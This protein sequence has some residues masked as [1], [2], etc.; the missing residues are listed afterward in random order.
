M[1]PI[2]LLAVLLPFLTA[3]LIVAIVLTVRYLRDKSKNEVIKRAI[4]AGK[5][6]T[7]EIFANFSKEGKKS[8]PLAA[9]LS[10][11]GAGIGIFLALYF[12]FGGLK[13]AAFGL[14]PLFVGIGQLISYFLNKK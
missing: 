4:E 8:D 10:T 3:I 5:E 1:E 13:F 2:E 9:A 6:I 7:P 14:I 12:F 11:I